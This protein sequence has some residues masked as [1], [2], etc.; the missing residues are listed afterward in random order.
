MQLWQ[1]QSG[2]LRSTPEEFPPKSDVFRRINLIRFPREISFENT[3]LWQKLHLLHWAKSERYRNLWSF[4]FF[5]V[6]DKISCQPMLAHCR[7]R[8]PAR[9][10][11]SCFCSNCLQFITPVLTWNWFFSSDLTRCCHKVYIY[12]AMEKMQPPQKPNCASH[13]RGRSG[14]AMTC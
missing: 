3:S 11:A 7:Q 9:F 8:K 14:T 13:F 2:N 12:L 4:C 6:F 10:S 1:K 5:E